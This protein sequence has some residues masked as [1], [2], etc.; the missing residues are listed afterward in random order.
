MRVEYDAAADS[1]RFSNPMY[2]QINAG[3]T[4]SQGVS[5]STTGQSGISLSNNDEPL[6][7]NTYTSLK[8]ITVEA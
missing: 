4:T 8:D 6:A 7:D 5:Q 1:T 2:D 3:E